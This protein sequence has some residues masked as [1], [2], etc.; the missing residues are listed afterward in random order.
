MKVVAHNP[1]AGR[2]AQVNLPANAYPYRPD[3]P[4]GVRVT[5][6]SLE[7]SVYWNAPANMRGVLKFRVYKG[8][9]NTLRFESLD[10]KARSCTIKVP[11]SDNDV[12]YVKSVG[13]K[14]LESPV[15]SGWGQANS[16]SYVAAGSTGATSGSGASEPSGW[17]SEPSGGLSSPIRTVY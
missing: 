13:A 11:A 1:L 14:G 16:D 4:R 10:H 2:F 6:G 5:G 7:V 3:P 17:S 8:D 9:E 15:A 12:Y